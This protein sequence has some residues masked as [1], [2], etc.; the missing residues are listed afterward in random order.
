M[1]LEGP[2]IRKFHAEWTRKWDVQSPATRKYS[3]HGSWKEARVAEVLVGWQLAHVT[4]SVQEH[5]MDM[6]VDY[7]LG[8][9]PGKHQLYEL[10]QSGY[11]I[12]KRNLYLS[13]SLSTFVLSTKR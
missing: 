11:F 1:G 9:H 8:G 5:L 13:A 12:G 4:L 7:A 3:T 6:D 10:N 2:A